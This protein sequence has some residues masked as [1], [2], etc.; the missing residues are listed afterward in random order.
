MMTDFLEIVEKELAKKYPEHDVEFG[1]LEDYIVRK[2]PAILVSPGTQN[3]KTAS[4]SNRDT[5]LGF[6]IT[7]IDQHIAEASKSEIKLCE[8]L[9]DFFETNAEIK[10]NI[11]YADTS[12]TTEIQKEEEDLN[13]TFFGKIKIN[14]QLRR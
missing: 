5:I 14:T 12:F 7:I 9:I 1:Y 2:L 8:S 13:G 3:R 4:L 11:V 6:N 10:K